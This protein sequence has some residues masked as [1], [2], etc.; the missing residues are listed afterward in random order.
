M[1]VDSARLLVALTDNQRQAVLAPSGPLLVLAGA[2]AGKTRVLTHRVAHWIASGAHEPGEILA[3]TFTNRAAG[4]LAERL[5]ALLASNA[6]EQVTTG[7]FHAICHRLLRT[8]APL[9]ERSAR[10]SIWDDGDR[11]RALRAVAREREL[12]V[13]VETAARAIGTAKAR[14]STPELMLAHAGSDHQRTVAHA[15]AGYEALLASS[16][17]LDFDDLLTAAVRLL[18]SRSGVRAVCRARWR[19]IVVDEYQDT[20]P[21]QA[22]WLE[23]LLGEDRN[24][25]ACGDDD[26]AIYRFRSADVGHILAFTQVHA[27]ARVIA[28][29]TNH[30]SSGAIVAASRRL[31]EHNAHRHAKPLRTDNPTARPVGVDALRDEY[32]EAHAAALWCRSQIAAGLSPAEIAVLFRARTQAGP[33]QEALVLAQVPHRLLGARGALERAE[34]RDLLAH[35]RLAVNPR[36]RVAFTRAAQSPRR[37]LGPAAIAALSDHAHEHGRDLVAACAD[38]AQVPGLRRPQADAAR[39]LAASSRALS[40]RADDPDPSAAVIAAL[41]ATGLLAA[42]KA[43][44]DAAERLDPLRELVRL[45]RRLHDADPA[46]TLRDLL[47][48]TA[49][50]G[51]AD[52]P[53]EDGQVTLSTVHAAKG[54][55]WC[56]VRVVGLQDG[57]FPHARALQEGQ[58][59][60][61]R[62]LAYVAFTRARDHL[63]LSWAGTRHGTPQLRSR[64]IAESGIADAP[65]ATAA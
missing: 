8:H 44:P 51:D 28:L 9:V 17:A 29:G 2:G 57:L 23:L 35:L 59:E 60:D 61:E 38:A 3:I 45:A 56:A 49:L 53:D 41:N 16:D 52:A 40:A 6:A 39:A 54:L 58:L 4:E 20:N 32:E 19:A 22:R 11:R 26:Q 55:E 1:P 50:L 10:F 65:L 30:R 21:A 48:H 12:D 37:G 36:D 5:G 46:A 24:L 34:V 62:R 13:D 64:F 43:R 31:I 15:W 7:T 18:D 27:G 33:L 63:S 47:A 42:V 14:L 25:T